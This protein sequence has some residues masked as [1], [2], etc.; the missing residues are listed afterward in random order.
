M[1]L[2]RSCIRKAGESTVYVRIVIPKDV[3]HAFDGRTT[4]TRTTGTSDVRLAEKRSHAILA[5]WHQQIAQARQATADKRANVPGMAAELGTLANEVAE[6]QLQ[7]AMGIRPGSGRSIEQSWAKVREMFEQLQMGVMLGK[8]PSAQLTTLLSILEGQIADA[9]AHPGP[10]PLEIKVRHAQK[11]ADFV[12]RV[13]LDDLR[14]A[15]A[16]T[17]EEAT[18]AHTYIL[19]PRQYVA[20]LPITKQRITAYRA[21]RENRGL[22]PKTVA[23]EVQQLEGIAAFL[24]QS[25]LPL[26][27]KTMA[28]WV[29]GSTLAPK[30]VAGYLKV[31]SAWWRWMLKYND[32][33]AQDHGTTPNPFDKHDLPRLSV[34]ASSAIERQEFAPSDVLRLIEAAT[35]KPSLQALVRMGAYTG[36]RIE[37][38]CTLKVD[39]VVTVDGVRA[40]RIVDAKTRAGVRTVPIHSELVALVDELIETT[41]DGHLLQSARKTTGDK[42]GKRSPTF[43][44]AFSLLKQELGYD[45]RLVFHSLRKTF[46]TELQRADTSGVIIAELV[47]HATGTVT[48]DV[49]ARGHSMAQLQSAVEKVRY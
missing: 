24:K 45:K 44:K 3:R 30:T 9:K 8:T 43:S 22:P 1:G 26:T 36:M 33:F 12:Q 49:Y 29:E 14:H 27:W 7:T 11:N 46:I 13:A 28:S 39:S 48:Y 35:L 15:A 38:L 31:G 10:L 19:N 20:P 37:E 5:E 32:Q 18:Q 17:P 21:F 6:R 47:G 42:Y 40:F 2:P 34:A 4:I 16:L 25:T 23:L 41:T